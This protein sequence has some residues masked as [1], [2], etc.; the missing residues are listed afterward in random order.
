[1]LGEGSAKPTSSALVSV[2]KE[3][4][5]RAGR[6]ANLPGVKNSQLNFCTRWAAEM[7]NWVLAPVGAELRNIAGRSDYSRTPVAASATYMR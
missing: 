3:G 2:G 4:A 5:A 6:R 1:V 7:S